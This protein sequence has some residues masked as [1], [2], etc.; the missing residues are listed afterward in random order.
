MRLTKCKF[1][2][3]IYNKGIIQQSF[4]KSKSNFENL[5]KNMKVVAIICE[6]NPFHKGHLEQIRYIREYFAPENVAILSLM[7]GNFVQRGD[8][9]IF[10]KY[11]RAKAALECGSD[12]VLELPFPFSMASAAIF[13]DSAVSIL[14]RLG[15]VDY[16]F[17]GS[18]NGDVEILK[19]TAD[20]LTSM[21]F[22]D[23]FKEKLSSSQSTPDS[24]ASVRSEVYKVLY[25]E[26]LF[27]TPNDI[28]GI[29]Y[30]IALKKR[31]SEII[32][33]AHKRIGG[34]SAT[35]SRAEI[36][37]GQGI[38]T[39]CPEQLVE[40]YQNQS[41][42]KLDAIDKVLLAHFRVSNVSGMS[43][44]A[45]N[46][47]SLTS[48]IAKYAKK[49][50]TFADTLE[51]SATKKYTHA[52]I[53]RASLY[54]L[55]GVHQTRLA[56]EPLYTRLLG[57]NSVGCGILKQIKKNCEI[58]VITKP[59]DAPKDVRESDQYECAERADSIYALAVEEFSEHYGEKPIIIK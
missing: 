44:C 48:R 59:A 15:C 1:C 46:E 2:D 32:P 18:E 57:A 26:K 25:Q 38:L 40:T 34:Y 11:D 31:S 17:F 54:S 27:D 43:Y 20:R 37:D 56:E 45:E 58:P 12:L 33:I 42:V 14:N 49:C 24:Y 23:F 36:K 41:P 47:L 3:I 6:Y 52:R 13:A 51:K 22:E 30:L 55:V 9:A 50:K 16:L 7:S 29:E 19:K 4:A 21:E 10:P 28:L 8:F 5:D 53:R 39:N 35:V